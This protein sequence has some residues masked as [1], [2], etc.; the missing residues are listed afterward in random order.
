MRVVVAGAGALGSLLGGY[1]AEAGAEVT[2]LARPA[3]A[4][5][6]RAG[7]LTVEGIRGRRVIGGL[8]ILDG[9][10]AVRSADLLIVAAKSF[11]TPDLLGSLA[12]LRGETG[13]A[14][15]VQNGGGKD[16]VLATALGTEAVVGAAT[17]VGAAM[18]EPGRVLHT[19]DGA[20]WIGELDGR[21]SERTGRIAA[22]FRQAGLRIEVVPDIRSATWCKLNQMVPAAALSLV[23]RLRLHEIYQQPDLAALFVELSLE[24]AGVAGRL[25]IP[26][27]DFEGFP[28][29][30]L[31]S[32]PRAAAVDSVQARGR[33]MQERGLTQV[34]ISTLQDLL[35]G[36]RTEAEQTIG[37][38]LELGA[39]QG[40]PLPMLTVFYRAIRGMEAALREAGETAR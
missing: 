10:H 39:R 9:P 29:K 18:P 17:I 32:L 2:L 3:H 15:S 28:V 26:L 38:V 6:I 8:R 7:G 1:L 27:G 14:L 12:H 5:A 34:R 24:V 4:E 35:R 23:T 40:V 11:D 31:C 30:T 13:A 25:G 37:Y 16:E 20:T 19:N 33:G 22:L 36:R 21:P